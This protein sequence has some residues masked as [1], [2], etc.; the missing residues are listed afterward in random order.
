MMLT[1]HSFPW[2][3]QSWKTPQAVTCVSL[4]PFLSLL[5][6]L[7]VPHT[8]P[9]TV[10][11]TDWDIRFHTNGAT[12]INQYLLSIASVPGI[13]SLA[14]VS[15]YE[16][17]KN[18]SCDRSANWWVLAK[19]HCFSTTVQTTPIPVTFHFL[20]AELG[21]RRTM[22]CCGLCWEAQMRGSGHGSPL[23]QTCVSQEGV[24]WAVNWSMLDRS[25]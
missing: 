11:S 8:A 22:L 7:L 18:S 14:S 12:L 3:S 17:K 23:R 24:P 21:T 25:H 5:V 13:K 15:F 20:S 1:G 6:V 19:C 16:A 4:I 10:L 2:P 9:V